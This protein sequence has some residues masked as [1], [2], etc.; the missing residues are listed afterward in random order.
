LAGAS[1]I[2]CD[3]IATLGPRQGWGRSVE[4]RRGRRRPA[5]A[6]R[7]PEL[8]VLVSAARRQRI[9]VPSHWWP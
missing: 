5:V 4:P 1:T 6:R 7:S 8:R 9:P 3:L 2:V